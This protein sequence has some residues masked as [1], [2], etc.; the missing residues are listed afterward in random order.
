MRLLF[1]DLDIGGANNYYPDD[2]FH[3]EADNPIY[4]GYNDR[5][6]RA[7]RLHHGRGRSYNT[8][9]SAYRRRKN[10]RG[11]RQSVDTFPIL[12]L[13]LPRTVKFCDPD[14]VRGSV[15]NRSFRHICGLRLSF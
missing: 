7:V 4:N 12:H 15:S 1:A 14:R 8:A 6:F 10:R 13:T 2:S 3:S 5:A 11:A 9:I